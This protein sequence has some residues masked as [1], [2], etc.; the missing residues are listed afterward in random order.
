MLS[1]ITPVKL[2]NVNFCRTESAD[3]SRQNATMQTQ[4]ADTFNKMVADRQKLMDKEEKRRKFSLGATALMTAAFLAMAGITI[5]QFVLGR[6]NGGK[7]VW[8]K[9]GNDI[10]KY[11]D[12]CVNKNVRDAVRRRLNLSKKSKEVR[13]YLGLNQVANMY[14]F[15]G[16]PG[17]GKSLSAKIMAKALNAEYAEVQFSEL[18]SEYVGKTAVN[19]THKFKEFYKLAK[20]NP[21]K[22]YVITFNEIDS[23]INN[24]EKLGV[25]NEH[26]GQNRTAFLNGVDL[27]KDCPNITIVGT[28]NID[29]H[30][31]RLDSAT[32]SRLGNIVEIPLPSKKELVSCLKFHLKKYPVA[33][34]VL[35]D[36]G[37][38]NELA[39]TLETKGASQRDTANIIDTSISA[40]GENINDTTSKITKDDILSIINDKGFWSSSTSG[41]DVLTSNDG[42]LNALLSLF[43]RYL[44]K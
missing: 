16:A 29:P 30:S 35:K 10:P 21:S 42:N 37:A 28:T 2:Q 9:L 43:S 4:D 20:K 40:F 32:L 23:L 22:Q 11:D 1:K 5:Y 6:G 7:T 44:G 34:N 14:L 27:I 25:N 19:I 41:S 39:E 38:L 15:W 12:D 18:S 13:E 8:R 33:E 26:L 17:T 36:E 31:A 3:N 24:V